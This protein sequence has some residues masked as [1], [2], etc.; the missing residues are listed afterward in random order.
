MLQLMGMTAK[1]Y[2]WPEKHAML[3]VSTELNGYALQSNQK[4]VWW[5]WLLKNVVYSIKRAQSTI[6]GT[7]CIV[8]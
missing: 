1:G 5:L 7:P 6:H 4:P 2:C 3:S 8:D